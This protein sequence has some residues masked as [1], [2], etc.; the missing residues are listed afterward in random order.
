V[1]LGNSSARIACYIVSDYAVVGSVNECDATTV[2]CYYVVS[3]YVVVGRGVE[4]DPSHS[5]VL[6][7]LLFL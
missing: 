7:K 1:I 2:V 5:I 3:D 4:V 6:L